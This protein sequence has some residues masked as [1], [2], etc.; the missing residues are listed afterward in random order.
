MQFGVVWHQEIIQMC[1]RRGLVSTGYEWTCWD[2]TCQWSGKIKRNFKETE[3]RNDVSITE[4]FYPQP[5]LESWNFRN[6]HSK[7]SR[8]K[9]YD[10]NGKRN[11][12]TDKKKPCL[13]NE[14]SCTTTSYVGGGES[15]L[16]RDWFANPRAFP[17]R[18][19]AT[20]WTLNC[21]ECKSVRLMVDVPLVIGAVGDIDDDAGKSGTV[22]ALSWYGRL[23]K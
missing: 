16:F 4:F 14:M 8:I 22:S 15:P 13:C 2:V 6:W 23:G 1:E 11:H 21:C 5:R 18:A 9:R 12:K 19:W 20:P 17:L 10:G 3:D 7:D